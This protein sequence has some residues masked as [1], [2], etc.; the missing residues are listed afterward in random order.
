LFLFF[1]PCFILFVIQGHDLYETYFFGADH[2]KYFEVEKGVY[3]VGGELD[4]YLN[5][6]NIPE[7]EIHTNIPTYQ[8]LTVLD[9]KI[10]NL[11]INRLKGELLFLQIFGFL[12]WIFS[13]I[14]SFNILKVIKMESHYSDLI[15]DKYH[16]IA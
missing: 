3:L 7:D 14:Q 2:Q 8:Y 1:V 9:G 16:Q 10:K 15:S 13:L 4:Q 6:F 12:I 5:V 11:N